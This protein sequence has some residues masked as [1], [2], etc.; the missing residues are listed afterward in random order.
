[1]RK[2]IMFV[3]L[4]LLASGAAAQPS[5]LYA[6]PQQRVALPGGKA[7]NLVCTGKG[8]PTV[9]L[10]AGAGDWSATWQRV[11]GPVAARTRVCAWDR[12]GLGFSDGSDQPLTAAAM[13]TDL[14]RTL[15]GSGTVGPYILVAHS[16]GAYETLVFAD[17]HRNEVSGM[18]LVDPSLPAMAKR[19]EAVSP[20]AARVLRADFA[21]RAAAFHHCA[22]DPSHVSKA[23]AAVCFHIPDS[24]T[25]FAATIERLNRQ[26]QR[27]TTL[28][29]L[30]EQ[31]EANADAVANLR[32][33]GAIPIAVLTSEK[34]PLAALPTE[35]P[36]RARG[37]GALW[38]SAHDQLAALSSDGSNQVVAG[39]EHMI[40][41]EHPDAVVSAI[42]KVLDEVQH[43]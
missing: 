20:L 29:T 9:I 18:V 23:E 8:T 12:P 28:A 34:Q 33:F 10:T 36:E 40:Q 37:L 25:P 31:F 30:Y 26:P 13:A 19:I 2:T 42:L 4:S 35:Q 16:A 11:Q 38:R 15:A 1:M 17:R 41:W 3:A 39:S 22:A 43:R 7:I 32:S 5:D 21:G 24:A 27:M 6:K 14:E